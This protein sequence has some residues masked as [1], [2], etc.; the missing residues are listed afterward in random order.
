MLR[1]LVDGVFQHDPLYPTECDKNGLINNIVHVGAS[2]EIKDDSYKT[3]IK[4]VHIAETA[5]T[6]NIEDTSANTELSQCIY[7]SKHSDQGPVSEK[8]E[9]ISNPDSVNVNSMN[10]GMNGKVIIKFS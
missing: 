5:Q 7:E 10:K 9:M 2:K 1:Y 3:E 8:A 4:G 6:V